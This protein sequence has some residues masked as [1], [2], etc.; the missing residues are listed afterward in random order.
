MQIV[1]GAATELSIIGG[2][3]VA[4]ASAIIGGHG[5]FLIIPGVVGV[6]IYE[7]YRFYKNRKVKEL[8]GGLRDNNN[9]E[10]ALEWE[11]YFKTLK[12]SNLL[13]LV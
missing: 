4:G 7:L 5:F 13:F 12:N 11:L 3:Y 1:I 9:T 10:Y 8:Y 2:A 6:G